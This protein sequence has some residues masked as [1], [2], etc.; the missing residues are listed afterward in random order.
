MTVISSAAY[1]ICL[2]I[3]IAQRFRMLELL[4]PFKPCSCR[5]RPEGVLPSELPGTHKGEGER[6]DSSRIRVRATSNV[7]RAF[8]SVASQPSKEPDIPGLRRVCEGTQ[9]EELER[10]GLDE[11]N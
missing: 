8:V 1:L 6:I 5:V 2:D 10:N 9:G 3:R 11:W 7:V 4:V